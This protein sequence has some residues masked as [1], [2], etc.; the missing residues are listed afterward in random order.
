MTFYLGSPVSL[1]GCQKLLFVETCHR[2]SLF[3][4][5]PISYKFESAFK[6]L[7]VPFREFLTRGLPGDDLFGADAIWLGERLGGDLPHPEVHNFG[8]A[9]QE[10]QPAR[11]VI[12]LRT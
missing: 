9:S 6:L 11:S 7:L 8:V 10:I 1:Q 4:S 5:L 3:A 2:L 12:K